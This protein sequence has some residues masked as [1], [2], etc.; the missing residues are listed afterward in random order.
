MVVAAAAAAAVVVVVVVVVV[1][2]ILGYSNQSAAVV[3]VVP[4]D[5]CAQLLRRRAYALPTSSPGSG[6]TTLVCDAHRWQSVE[7][8]SC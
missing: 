3:L 8:Q 6:S 2:G 7:T 4:A 1:A 5:A